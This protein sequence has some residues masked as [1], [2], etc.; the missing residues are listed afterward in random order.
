[1]ILILA[2]RWQYLITTLPFWECHLISKNL[3]AIWEFLYAAREQKYAALDKEYAG[4]DMFKRALQI[5]VGTVPIMG[6]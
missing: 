6:K 4:W 2:A 1:M 5:A 3:H